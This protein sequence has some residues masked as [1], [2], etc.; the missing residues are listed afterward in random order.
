[1]VLKVL[2]LWRMKV[3]PSVEMSV[4][5][6]SNCTC[7]RTVAVKTWWTWCKHVTWNAKNHAK[8]PS[9]SYLFSFLILINFEYGKPMNYQFFYWGGRL[10]L[11]TSCKLTEL[12]LNILFT[13]PKQFVRQWRPFTK[14][15]KKAFQYDAYLPLTN[16]MCL[17]SHQMSVKVGAPEQWGPMSKGGLLYNEVPYPMGDVSVH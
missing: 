6:G 7:I 9:Q 2:R 13:K 17:S 12:S 15:N 5:H 10:R 16:F 3:I 4:C 8:I 14:H 1:M 11:L